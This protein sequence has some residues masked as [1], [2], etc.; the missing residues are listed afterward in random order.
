MFINEHEPMI[1]L[2]FLLLFFFNVILSSS[3]HILYIYISYDSVKLIIFFKRY[4]LL[5][6]IFPIIQPF[7]FTYVV[8]IGHLYHTNVNNVKPAKQMW[9]F[10]IVK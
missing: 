10:F 6:I 3:L 2:Y 4:Y 5:L 7:Y 8:I 1:F 9:Q